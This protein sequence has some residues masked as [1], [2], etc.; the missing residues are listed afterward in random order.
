VAGFFRPSSAAVQSHDDP[1][2][3]DHGHHHDDL[4]PK[5]LK[6]LDHIVEGV[7]SWCST[8]RHWVT[9]TED[10]C[11][12]E[13]DEI[14]ASSSTWGFGCNNCD[15]WI[16]V[17]SCMADWIQ[18][19]NC[20]TWQSLDEAWASLCRARANSLYN[21]PVTCEDDGETTYLGWFSSE[22]VGY[23]WCG[24]QYSY[25]HATGEISVLKPVASTGLVPTWPQLQAAQALLATRGHAPC[26]EVVKTLEGCCPYD[27]DDEDDGE[28]PAF[29]RKRR[30]RPG[31]KQRAN[32]TK[33]NP[34]K[35]GGCPPPPPPPAQAV[36]A[37][38]V[39]VKCPP[40]T[41]VSLAWVLANC[42]KGKANLDVPCPPP[43][44]CR[45]VHFVNTGTGSPFGDEEAALEAAWRQLVEDE[46]VPQQAIHGC[47]LKPGTK[48]TYSPT[49]GP[50]S[51]E[52]CCQVDYW[53]DPYT[54]KG[55]LPG[56]LVCCCPPQQ[57]DCPMPP[58]PPPPPPDPLPPLRSG[59]PRKKKQR[60]CYIA[61][62]ARGPSEGYGGVWSGA[63]NFIS[64][65]LTGETVGDCTGDPG[66]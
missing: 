4:C 17:L 10:G 35:G 64:L 33:G 42:N 57:P 2:H 62:A 26:P 27:S 22:A 23:C 32:P 18:C 49:G 8:C 43:P 37:C 66:G 51:A 45:T 54:K 46:G 7:P 28:T 61:N 48:I 60:C 50:S 34:P 39:W 41:K 15:N 55:N 44:T 19:A 30:P 47:S 12:E 20:L 29:E 24:K 53:C 52:V 3:R 21:I 38:P 59:T 1:S 58:P 6:H 65:Y 31:R 14:E 9:A 40:W 63:Q 16:T 36:A 56:G 25:N 5:C 11:K 13:G